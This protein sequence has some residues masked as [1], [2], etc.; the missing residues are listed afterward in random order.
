VTS[1]AGRTGMRIG[2][3]YRLGTLI[4][5]GGMG[6][7]YAAENVLTGKRVAIKCMN[8]GLAS[9]PE[10]AARFLREAKASARIRHPNVVDVY[11]VLEEGDGL[12]L[13][14]EL[15]EGE[16]LSAFLAR[17]T[18]P[19]P[20]LI[21]LLIPAMRGVAAAHRH[22]VVHRD[23]KPE[24]IFLAVEGEDAEW[25]PKVLD[26]GISKLQGTQEIA[27]TAPGN[28]L[29]TLLYMA[30][31]Q[32]DGVSDVDARADVYALGV[33]LYQ[34]ITGQFP[35]Y[36]DSVGA[37]VMQV[38]SAQ[39]TPIQLLR[40][41]V[42]TEL[43]E[44]IAR[45]MAKDRE[46]RFQTMAELIGALTPFADEAKYGRCVTRM[47][48]RPALE[49][50]PKQKLPPTAETDRGTEA[51]SARHL[52][53]E[54][55]FSVNVRSEHMTR[56]GW[57]RPGAALGGVLLL[58]ACAWLWVQARPTRKVPVQAAAVAPAAATVELPTMPTQRPAL[59]PREPTQEPAGPATP[60]GV[61]APAVTAPAAPA[62]AA[63]TVRV[64]RTEPS[65]RSEPAPPVERAGCSPNFYFDAK[66][67]K[68][69]KR[70]CF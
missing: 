31:E 17:E 59:L 32:L 69:F 25:V 54:T 33:I 55:P 49:L 13:I 29:G 68:H 60:R 27:L 64:P 42:P 14:M 66:G 30:V 12:F 21:R 48:S 67:D 1:G 3:K 34:A 46:Q 8:V 5:K 57:L 47:S 11:D 15:L 10:A 24:N 26:F 22:G 4:G 65:R 16:P 50:P 53:S 7:V 39:P 19:L 45:A 40:R 56:P 18:I 6:A 70:D 28:M 23:V 61:A 51:R 44:T 2:G 9:G 52:A 37:L 41:D 43:A 63:P 20:S 58:A 38:F 35:Y 36:A 62:Q